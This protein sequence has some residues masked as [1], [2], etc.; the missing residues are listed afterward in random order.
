[1]TAPMQ[2]DWPNELA[3]READA[4]GDEHAAVADVMSAIFGPAPTDLAQLAGALQKHQPTRDELIALARIQA[5]G[6]LAALK[7][8]EPGPAALLLADTLAYLD[9]AGRAG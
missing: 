3:A 6:A 7:A 9:Q 2:P 1:M 4:A 8:G 5:K